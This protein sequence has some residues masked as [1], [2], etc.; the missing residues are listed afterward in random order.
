MPKR[1]AIFVILLV[2]VCE[3]GT[4]YVA[5]DGN[6]ETGNGSEGNPWATIEHAKN[7]IVGT[8]GNT[9]YVR[10]G[11]YYFGE[12]VDVNELDSGA[13]GSPNIY[14]A[15][16]GENPVLCGGIV[17]SPSWTQHS[18]NIYKTSTPD[19]DFYTLWVDGS[20]ATRSREPDSGTY[21]VVSASGS[22]ISFTFDDTLPDIDENWT[23]LTDIEIICW[24][25]SG[26]ICSRQRISSVNGTLVT[27]ANARNQAYDY[28]SFTHHFIC[29]NGIDLLDSEG[30]WYH[31][32][33]TDTLYYYAVGGGSP[34]GIFLAG[35]L[36]NTVTATTDGRGVI[37]L[38]DGRLWSTK[39]QSGTFVHDIII[40]GFTFR[41]TDF[42]VPSFG[43]KGFQSAWQLEYSTDLGGT[44]PAVSFVYATNCQLLNCTIEQ[45]GGHGLTIMGDHITVRHN[46]I[47]HTG[48][49]GIRTGTNYDCTNCK[50]ITNYNTIE[51]NTIHDVGKIYYEGTGI[52][53]QSCEGNVII[54]NDVYNAGY[55]GISVGWDWTASDYVQGDNLIAYNDVWNTN[56]YLWDGGCIYTLS[57]SP[58][59]RI[60]HNK[61]HGT[62]ATGMYL[63]E[64]SAYILVSDNWIYDIGTGLHLH[65]TN[66]CQFNNNVIVDAT[67]A[68]L[69]YNS[70]ANNSQ[71]HNVVYNGVGSDILFRVETINLAP[72][73][74]DY[75]NDNYHVSGSS[76]ALGVGFEQIAGLHLVGP[77]T[78]IK[79]AGF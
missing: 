34:T 40:D 65:D 16:S 45:T 60:H 51:D 24:P 29:E 59:T 10:G 3:A 7:E 63:D 9:V 71:T 72:D 32:R 57:Y 25:Y 22:N 75:D 33:S 30:E 18:G 2:S 53:L 23:G 69:Q 74:V 21:T 66:Y 1:V 35:N 54:H 28:A 15:Y 46:T 13:S 17:L 56:Q 37:A 58:N 26:W 61:C 20:R 52:L 79:F 36:G 8:T 76:P 4:Y 11:T 68:A 27:L 47:R 41:N 42:V 19:I 50:E 48:A 6:D 43:Y 73:F 31:D 70:G 55:N 77:R 67:W 12:A 44:G 38:Y 78:G 62:N 14:K 49:S 5:T 39:G 64:K